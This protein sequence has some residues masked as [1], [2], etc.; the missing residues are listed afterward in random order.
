MASNQIETGMS[1]H[2]SDVSPVVPTS[3]PEESATS[4]RRF[5]IQAYLDQDLH[6]PNQ[7]SICLV[8][9]R[10]CLEALGIAV[11]QALKLPS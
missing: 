3:S 5:H 1:L 8:L 9:G 6:G 4:N 2:I 10:P 11:Q 7:R